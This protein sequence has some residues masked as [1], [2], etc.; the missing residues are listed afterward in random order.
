MDGGD[1][2][3]LGESGGEG[4]ID[5]TRAEV[6]VNHVNSSLPNDASHS[7]DRNGI[8]LGANP[9]FGDGETQFT[10]LAGK[11]LALEGKKLNGMTRLALVQ[12]QGAQTEGGAVNDFPSAADLKDPQGTTSHH[13][14]T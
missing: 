12:R 14:G 1:G 8:D 7:N 2:W 5:T 13:A 11:W 4:A 6:G 3:G 9:D 10:H